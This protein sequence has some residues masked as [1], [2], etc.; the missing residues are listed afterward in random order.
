MDASPGRDQP[1]AGPQEVPGTA[2][3][4]RGR[5]RGSAGAALQHHVGPDDRVYCGGLEEVGSKFSVDI[6]CLIF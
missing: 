5:G 3:D 6:M 4:L 1:P 2:G